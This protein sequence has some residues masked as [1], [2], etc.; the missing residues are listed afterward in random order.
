[1]SILPY[2]PRERLGRTLA[3]ADVHLI[4]LREEVEGLIVPS[5][6]YG[7]MAAGRPAVFVGPTGSEVARTL[8]EQECGFVVPVGDV[9][10]LVG[11]LRLLQADR[12]LAGAMGLRARQALEKHFER[13]DCC[14]RLAEI[15]AEVALPETARRR[16]GKQAARGAGR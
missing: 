13:D 4:S 6:L 12:D 14:G 10:G 2:Q 11:R 8:V 5:K 9:E 1:M 3:A 7:I 16:N 15:L